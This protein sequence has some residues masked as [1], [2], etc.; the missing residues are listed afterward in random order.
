MC[1]SALLLCPQSIKA[2]VLINP[3]GWDDDDLPLAQEVIPYLRLSPEPNES[4]DTRFYKTQFRFLSR[5]LGDGEHIR[6]ADEETVLVTQLG[7]KNVLSLS[8]DGVDTVKVPNDSRVFVR[9]RV[10]DSKVT[11][12]EVLSEIADMKRFAHQHV[13]SVYASYLSQGTISILSLP[14]ASYTLKSFLMDPPK[15]WSSLTKSERRQTLINYPHCMSNALSWLHQHGAHHGALRPSNIYVDSKFQISLGPMDGPGVLCIMTKSDDIESYQY[16]PPERWKRAV[17]VQSAGSA[18]VALPSGGRSARKVPSTMHEPADPSTRKRSGSSFGT[19]K[20]ERSDSYNFQPTSKSEFARFRLSVST[21]AQPVIAP[22][23]RRRQPARPSRAD[24][25]LERRK[26]PSHSGSLRPSSVVSTGSSGE[27]IRAMSSLSQGTFAAAHEKKSAVVQTWRSVQH[28]SFA[29]DVFS[30]GAV[31]LDILTILCKKTYSSFAR[32]RS[33][34]NRNAGRGGGLADASFHANLGQVMLWAQSL[35]DE[36]E[37]KAKKEDSKVLRAVGPIV[38][39]V[40]QCLERQPESRLKSHQ[41][42]RTLEE[43][44]RKFASLNDLHCRT[45]VPEKQTQIP[46]RQRTA[47][48][49]ASARLERPPA[50]SRPSG[51]R[52]E[53]PP[54]I[55][56]D[57]SRPT[58]SSTVRRPASPP[59]ASVSSFSSA[60]FDIDGRSDTV[61]APGSARSGDHSL[62]GC[63]RKADARQDIQSWTDSMLLPS[64]PRM[65]DYSQSNESA[66]DPR[67]TLSTDQGSEGGVFTYLNYSTSP[68]D[69]EDASIY[70][71]PLPP[72]KAPTRQLPPVPPIPSPVPSPKMRSDTRKNETQ[73]R[74]GSEERAM[75]R[76]LSR[77]ANE[78][79]HPPREDSLATRSAQSEVRRDIKRSFPRAENPRASPNRDYGRVYRPRE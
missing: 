57:S 56:S 28:D 47:S 69:D 12:E 18:K 51:I 15:V 16:A 60:G 55:S 5:L 42:E 48:D 37:K 36:A 52:E 25:D 49:L 58:T 46:V 70:H 59:N 50:R 79:W 32:H 66:V 63:N 54:T 10:L 19:Y 68:S 31:M 23:P 39:V 74:S 26:V 62:H 11:E 67:L 78:G 27:R 76:K 13:E 71:Y 45:A 77:S 17:T 41:L 24:S 3:Q 30:M 64:F 38:Q 2:Q 9:R 4:L 53:D 65:L 34:K 75:L 22:L 33:A 1:S 7:L 35:A 73:R 61:V 29:A 21:G 40:L 72:T 6:Y 14:A 43:Y 8:K 44:T 20:T